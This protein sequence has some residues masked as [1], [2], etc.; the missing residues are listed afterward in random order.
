MGMVTASV[1]LNVELEGDYGPI[2]GVRATCTKCRHE[3]ES[4]G[5]EDRSIKRCLVVMRE[6]CPRRE[7]NFDRKGV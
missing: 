5:T 6:E 4:F 3:V 2:D 7:K 1:E